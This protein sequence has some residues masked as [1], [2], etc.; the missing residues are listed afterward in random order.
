MKNE[1]RILHRILRKAVYYYWWGQK[2]WE[3]IVYWFPSAF[4]LRLE[5]VVPIHLR[6]RQN[7]ILKETN[8]TKL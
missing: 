5:A 1:S 2:H 4:S 6:G 7:R 8:K 3:L